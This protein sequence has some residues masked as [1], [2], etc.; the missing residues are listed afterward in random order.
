MQRQTEGGREWRRTETERRE[1]ES[2]EVS[3]PLPMFALL[4]P[5]CSNEH[6]KSKQQQ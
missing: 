6:I 3:F 5:I 2:G 1:R 4:A